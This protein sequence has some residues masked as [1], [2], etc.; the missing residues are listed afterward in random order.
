[1]RKTKEQRA[2]RK[3][4]EKRYRQENKPE[5]NRKAKRRYHNDP[6][7]RVTYAA[8]R[9]V[10]DALKKAGL[11]KSKRTIK[12]LGCTWDEYRAWLEPQLH[13]GMTWENYGT[14]WH[15]DHT[16]PVAPAIEQFGEAALP[17]VFNYRNCKPM[18]AKKNLR[19]KCKWPKREDIEPWVN[20]RIEELV[21]ATVLDFV[22]NCK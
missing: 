22:E 7:Y 11:R 6:L 17:V 19:K 21:L 13:D 10:R 14:V 12:L 16:V 1:M 8:R 3:E 20:E 18:L 2:A 5:R 4:Y 15:V 9:R